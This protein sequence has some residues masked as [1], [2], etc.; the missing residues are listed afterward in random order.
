MSD[1]RLIDG[2]TVHYLKCW[3]EYFQAVKSGAKPFEIR[4]N[5]RDYKVGD[6]LILKEWHMGM[7]KYTGDEEERTI[8]YMTTYNQKSGYV[9]LGLSNQGEAARQRDVLE[10]IEGLE[11]NDSDT[12]KTLV[13]HI[14][15]QALSFHTEDT[16]IQKVRELWDEM[17]RQD[18]FYGMRALKG[19]LIALGITIPGITDGGDNNAET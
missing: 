6:V 7:Q 12:Y 10:R 1:K 16:G 4:E 11:L 18:G 13:K 5:D 9:V 15:K 2:A 17:K 14:V 8:S 19:S 3:P